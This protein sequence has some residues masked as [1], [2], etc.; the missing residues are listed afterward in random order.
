LIAFSVPRG[1]DLIWTG[2]RLVIKLVEVEV[3]IGIEVD[4][5]GGDDRRENLSRGM[6]LRDVGSITIVYLPTGTFR[7]MRVER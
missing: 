2:K 5:G 7:T 4:S 3:E 1:R 6:E